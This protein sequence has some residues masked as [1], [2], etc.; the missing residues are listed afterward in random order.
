MQKYKETD[1]GTQIFL[2]E[3]AVACRILYFNVFEI[4]TA[5]L[6]FPSGK[7]KK[8]ADIVFNALVTSDRFMTLDVLNGNVLAWNLV[9]AK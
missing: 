7:E 5:S 8:V 9:L 4:F 6:R 1:T 3:F 2:D